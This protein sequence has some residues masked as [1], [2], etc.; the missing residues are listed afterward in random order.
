M[1]PDEREVREQEDRRGISRRD[2]VRLAAALALGTGLGVPAELLAAAPS[3]ARL[4][5]KF[6]KAPGDGGTLVGSTDLLDAVSIFL[7][8][9]AGARVQVKWYDSLARELGTMG[10]PS[11]IQD[12]VRAVMSEPGD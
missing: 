5:I 11:M 3:A 2:S 6:Y 9:P 8:S 1:M 10:I 7:G 4:Q 12:K